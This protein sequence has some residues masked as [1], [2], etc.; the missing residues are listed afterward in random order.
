MF[1]CLS[2]QQVSFHG[3][4][5]MYS[6]AQHLHISCFHAHVLAVYEI[7]L[8]VMDLWSKESLSTV[9]DCPAAALD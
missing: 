3:L 7:V 5:T 9:V 4:L 1:D 6:L 2:A 8:M